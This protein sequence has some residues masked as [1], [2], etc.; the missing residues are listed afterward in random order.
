MGR[1]VRDDLARQ[2]HLVRI[3]PH[4]PSLMSSTL[5]VHGSGPGPRQAA[6]RGPSWGA[7]QRIACRRQ[8]YRPQRPVERSRHDRA[9]LARARPRTGCRA[10][11]RRSRPAT[12]PMR[13]RSIQR[14]TALAL[15]TPS[16]LDPN[17]PESPALETPR[18][19]PYDARAG[20]VAEWLKALVL[21][22][23]VGETPPWVRIPPHPP[24]A[25]AKAFSRSG[26]GRI[27]SLF[28]RVMC[29]R[30]CTGVLDTAAGYVLWSPIF[31]GPLDC[32]ISV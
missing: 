18:W 8:A 9:A 24:L 11:R 1:P 25:L 27:F 5:K 20:W 22:T 32:S 3:V 10:L 21:K 19:P 26:C 31:S 17:A 16:R 28:S 7:G 12:A 4:L 23:S 14:M 29:S 6:V 30:L 13:L 2:G 15:R